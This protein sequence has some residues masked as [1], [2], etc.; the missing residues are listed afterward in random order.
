[1][2]R[3]VAFLLAYG[4]V[5]TYQRHSTFLKSSVA[6]ETVELQRHCEED[7]AWAR[8]V[9]PW[10]IQ[11]SLV[12]MPMGPPGGPART[13]CTRISRAFIKADPESKKV[14]IKMLKT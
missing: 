9:G 5:S 4:R 10:S 8:L 7:A 2:K 13:G 12:Q 3:V 1:M 14:N 11:P 6:G